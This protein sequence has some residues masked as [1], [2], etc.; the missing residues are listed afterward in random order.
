[1]LKHEPALK[2]HYWEM[3]AVHEISRLV[4]PFFN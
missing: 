4:K 1:M 3:G 2:A